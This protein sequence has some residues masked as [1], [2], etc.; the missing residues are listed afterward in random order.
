MPR[1]ESVIEDTPDKVIAKELVLGKY[2]PVVDPPVTFK[3]G[4]DAD[5]ADKVSVVADVVLTV[6]ALYTF[7]PS[8]TSK[9]VELEGTVT[10]CPPDT[11][12]VKVNVYELFVAVFVIVYNCTV[13]GKVTVQAEVALTYCWIVL[14]A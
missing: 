11:P 8:H 6:F 1:E 10:V 14:D 9:D 7:V 4:A 3:E 2:I 12:V 13:L 5:P